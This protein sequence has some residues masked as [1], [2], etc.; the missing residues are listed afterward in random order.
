[1]NCGLLSRTSSLKSS[2]PSQGKNNMWSKLT[3]S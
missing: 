3:V 1:M 2:P